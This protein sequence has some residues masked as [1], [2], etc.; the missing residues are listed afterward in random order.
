MPTLAN[1]ATFLTLLLVSM[2][3]CYGFDIVIQNQFSSGSIGKGLNYLEDR[4]NRLTFNDLPPISEWQTLDKDTLNAGFTRSTYWGYFTLTNQSDTEQS[5]ILEYSYPLLDKINLHINQSDE[6]R[7]ITIGNDLPF[8]SRVISHS[9]LLVPLELKPLEK[10]R[11]WF[12]VKTSSTMQIPITLWNQQAYLEKTHK[13]SSYFGIFFGVLFAICLYHL[14]I[15]FSVRDRSYLYYSL[16]NLSML[17]AFLCLKGFP[18]AFLWPSVHGL[19]DTI[20]LISICGGAAFP[21]LFSNEILGVARARPL[22]SKALYAVGVAALVLAAG[23]LL[24][25]YHVMIKLVLLLAGVSLL[26]NGVAHVVRLIDGFPAAKYVF[27]AGVFSAVG[28]FITILEKAGFLPHSPLFEGAAYGGVLSMTM[29]YAFALS[30]Q[31]NKDRT[32]K[33]Q[34]QRRLLETQARLNSDLDRRVAE[35]THEKEKMAILLRTTKALSLSDDNIRS[36]VITVKH[37]HEILKPLKLNDAHFYCAQQSSD[38]F[39]S[40]HLCEHGVF[41]ENVKA[42]E[43][44]PTRAEALRALK[45][46]GLN[47]QEILM[48]IQSEKKRWGVLTLSSYVGDKETLDFDLLENLAQ[49]LALSLENIASEQNSRLASIGAMAAA[50]VHDLKNP[51][52]AIKG[53]AELATHSDVESERNEYLDTIIGEASRMSV[54]AHEVLEYSRN[55]IQLALST[56]SPKAFLE[57]ISKLLGQLFQPHGIEFESH[58]STDKAITLDIERIRRSLINIATNARDALINARIPNPRCT[59]TFTEENNQFAIHMAD[60]GPGIP[61]A[62]HAILFEP[63]VT[64]GKSNGTGLGMAIVKKTIDA[65]HGMISFATSHDMG[66]TFYLSF[67]QAFHNEQATSQQHYPLPKNSISLTG[68]RALVAEDNPVN[69]KIIQKTLESLGLVCHLTHN[70]AEAVQLASKNPFDVILLDIEMPVMNGI[71]ACQLIR[72]QSLHQNTPIIALT[73]HVAYGSDDQGPD[74]YFTSILSKPF[75]RD[76]LESSLAKSFHITLST[77]GN[78]A[79]Q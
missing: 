64:H 23:S 9:A 42:N 79:E 58:C 8:S 27:L 12:Q 77:L 38:A 13:V 19:S 34:M 51:I 56:V 16:F 17:G 50:I 45:K 21:C 35:R 29:L 37:L 65:H 22:L 71:D 18:T 62:I 74:K 63:F 40:Y 31:M 41:V 28:I 20:L 48:P 46:T 26:V 5:L 2:R 54:M 78:V 68:K 25:P 60:N 59:L 39:T 33:D 6:L 30:F 15:F 14:L 3:V 73:G 66:T 52:G 53:C 36:A 70:G 69:Q 67:S 47:G 11:V 32:L 76:A 1:V 7:E 49:S 72:K 55:D 61:E 44:S 75:T 24:F 4:T 10:A 43:T 57:D